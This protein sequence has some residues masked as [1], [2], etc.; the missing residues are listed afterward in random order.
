MLTTYL[1]QVKK[2]RGYKNGGWIN[3][4]RRSLAQG[5]VS[6][7]NVKVGCTAS[8]APSPQPGPHSVGII[9][10]TPPSFAIRQLDTRYIPLFRALHLTT[11]GIKYQFLLKLMSFPGPKR[12]I[13]LQGS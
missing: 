1:Q 10:S 3:N 9:C 4:V 5:V 7:K 2:K 11:A 12:D 13:Q 6:C 8:P